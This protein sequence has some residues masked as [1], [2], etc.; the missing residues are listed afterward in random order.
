LS[1]KFHLVCRADHPLARRRQLAFRDV[2][3]LPQIRFDRTSS[4][5]QHVDAAFYPAQPVTAMEVNQLVTAAG[6]IA[7]GIGVTLAPTL[8]LVEFRMAGLVAIPVQLPIKDRELCVVRRRDSADS[9]AASA[10][11]E[12]LKATWDVDRRR[13]QRAGGA[14]VR[15]RARAVKSGR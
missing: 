11:V 7:I 12:V 6:L 2:A 5:R 15:N 1:D 13:P 10:F 4:I 14:A 9:V 8:A 3:K